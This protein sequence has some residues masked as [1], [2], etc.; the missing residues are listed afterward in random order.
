[1]VSIL[2]LS[3]VHTKNSCDGIFHSFLCLVTVSLDCQLD[4]SNQIKHTGQSLA[5]TVTVVVNTDFP[6]ITFREHI[7]RDVLFQGQFPVAQLIKQSCLSLPGCRFTRIFWRL[8]VFCRVLSFYL[9]S[10]PYFWTS[11]DNYYDVVRV[12]N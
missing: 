4:F 12:P 5:N 8:R 10:S 6:P 3:S 2:Y 11:V 7:V 1:M 9:S